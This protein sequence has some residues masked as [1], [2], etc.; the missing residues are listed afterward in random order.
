M[1]Y[2]LEGAGGSVN[3]H[4]PVLKHYLALLLWIDIFISCDPA[5]L[6]LAI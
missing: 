1:D 2:Y 4:K 5:I 6:L 3:W